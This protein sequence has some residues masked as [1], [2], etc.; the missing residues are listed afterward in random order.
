[1]YEDGLPGRANKPCPYVRLA[2]SASLPFRN[3]GKGHETTFHSSALFIPDCFSFCFSL[4]RRV[5]TKFA[6]QA[7]A[8]RDVRNSD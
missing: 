1:M 8:R 7:S 4:R 3:T 5:S 2:A 6:S